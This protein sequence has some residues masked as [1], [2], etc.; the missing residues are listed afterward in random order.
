MCDRATIR[1]TD[2]SVIADIAATIAR[3]TEADKI[4]FLNYN[5]SGR[6]DFLALLPGKAQ[7]SFRQYQY[8]VESGCSEY[9][10]VMLWCCHTAQAYKYLHTGHIFYSLACI[11][12]KLVYNNNG[13]PMPDIS[14][15]SDSAAIEQAKATFYSLFTL[16]QSFLDGANYHAAKGHLLISVFSLHQATE[17]AL[18]A[19]ILVL[20]GY[21][22]RGHD[23]GISLRHCYYCAPSLCRIFPQDTE[24]EKAIYHLLNNAYL[25]TRYKNSY[26]IYSTELTELIK[27]VSSLH[28]QVLCLFEERLLTFKTHVRCQTKSS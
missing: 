17:H 24:S 18:R 16:A 23:L 1:A 12:E 28:V 15:V 9:G 26:T 22:G 25:H 14:M 5:A 13:T 19:L 2:K 8:L 6:Y 7:L 3:L 4:F 21:N 27:R 20:T 10:S 11:P